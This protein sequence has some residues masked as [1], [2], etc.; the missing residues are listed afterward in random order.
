MIAPEKKDAPRL[1]SASIKERSCA[2]NIIEVEF[3]QEQPLMPLEEAH[4]ILREQA[5]RAK[6]FAKSHGVTV[7]DL[8]QLCIE[9]RKR[10]LP[11]VIVGMARKTAHSPDTALIEGHERT[12]LSY[13]LDGRNGARQFL[14]RVAEQISQTRFTGQFSAASG[15]LSITARPSISSLYRTR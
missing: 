9:R 12:I 5:R 6:L 13:L 8:V 1:K 3:R 11:P 14:H 15:T 7:D 10:G 4:A 2:N